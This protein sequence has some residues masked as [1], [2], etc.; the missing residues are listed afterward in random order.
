MAVDD[1][2][3]RIAR[4]NPELQNVDWAKAHAFSFKGRKAQM[5]FETFRG[6]VD[7]VK[8]GVLHKS[9]SMERVLEPVWNLDVVMQMNTIYVAGSELVDVI[10]D[11]PE[12]EAARV[13]VR[14]A[15][16]LKVLESVASGVPDLP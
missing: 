13:H 9:L 1:E 5:P 10:A 11:L 3:E 16:L 8:R 4:E 7:R 15:Y 12:P 6:G 14:Q 2:F